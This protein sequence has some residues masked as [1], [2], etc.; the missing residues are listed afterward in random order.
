MSS[1]GRR[2]GEARTLGQAPPGRQRHRHD[3]MLQVDLRLAAGRGRRLQLDPD[4]ERPALHPGQGGRFCWASSWKAPV[5]VVDWFAGSAGKV[6]WPDGVGGLEDVGLRG[7][8]DVERGA[9]GV[10]GA[11][12]LDLDR[13]VQSPAPSMFWMASCG[14]PRPLRSTRAPPFGWLLSGGRS[15]V[16]VPPLYGTVA[17][18]EAGP[19]KGT[20]SALTVRAVCL[21]QPA[22]RSAR[23]A[24][25]ARKRSVRTGWSRHGWPPQN[26]KPSEA[27]TPK[28]WWSVKGERCEVSATS[29]PT[30]PVRTPTPTP[31]RRPSW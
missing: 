26:P 13:E 3:E 25:S 5:T 10:D 1:P 30:G 20:R 7:R 16:V 24:P 31:S 19:R 12:G 22:R 4:P 29:R 14:T 6:T 21:E 11:V 9:A 17:C 27:A 18:V 2:L 28:A 8:G 15:R 23:A